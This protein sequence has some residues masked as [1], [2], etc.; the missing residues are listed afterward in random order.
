ML[1][2]SEIREE[3]IAA[4]N[5]WN[6]TLLFTKMINSLKGQAIDL[7]YDGYL[8]VRDEAGESPFN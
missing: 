8:I 1:P 3:Y 7:D 4:S 5:I 6:R 2:F